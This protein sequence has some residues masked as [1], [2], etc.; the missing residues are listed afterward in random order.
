MKTERVAY[1]CEGINFNGYLAHNEKLKEKKPVVLIAHAWRGQDNFAREKAEFLAELGYV[2]F[3][4]DLYGD[5]RQVETDE[6][7]KQLMV[8]LFLDRKALRERIV[9]AY[10]TASNLPFVDSEK[11]GAIGFCFGG[12]TVI[13][14]LRSGVPLKGVVSLHGLLGFTLGEKRAT[15]V[16]SA[17]KLYGSLLILHGYRDPMVSHEDIEKTQAEFSQAGIDWQM[18]IYGEAAHAF[19]N[20]TANEPENG[21]LYHAK[22][23]KRAIQTMR[24]FFSEVFE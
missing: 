24:N 15:P 17:Q 11:I 16:P 10:H 14:L 6:E 4:V 3:A 13:E 2:G 18:H 7:A 23:E 9:L 8:P 5:G 1:S 19:T 12:L 20:P 22:A 21:L